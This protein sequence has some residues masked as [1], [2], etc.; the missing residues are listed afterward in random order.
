MIKE[1]ISATKKLTK[2]SEELS[3]IFQKLKS[4]PK[5]ALNLLRAFRDFN[6]R[7]IFLRNFPTMTKRF[8]KGHGAKSPTHVFHQKNKGGKPSKE[9]IHDNL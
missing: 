1:D 5:M 6:Y 8:P 2:K 3:E 9:K 4:S 7:G